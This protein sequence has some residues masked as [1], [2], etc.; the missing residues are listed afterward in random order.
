MGHGFG[1]DIDHRGLTL[2][3]EVGK[4]TLRTY[5]R[6]FAVRKVELEAKSHPRCKRHDR[7]RLK[8]SSIGG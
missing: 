6:R 5:I 8:F 3:V 7:T 2:G 4:H 1:S